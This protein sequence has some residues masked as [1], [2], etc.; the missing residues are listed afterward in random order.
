MLTAQSPSLADACPSFFLACSSTSSWQGALPGNEKKKL[1]VLAERFGI[2]FKGQAHRA[3]ADVGVM[4]ELLPYLMD[5]GLSDV[6]A[7]VGA[8]RGC[9]RRMGCKSK[10]QSIQTSPS[11]KAVFGSKVGLCHSNSKK[12][13]MQPHL[14]SPFTPIPPLLNPRPPSS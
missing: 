1:G 14:T 5:M 6:T 10:E 3:E 11:T 13:Q 7:Q 9:E 8:E 2:Q 12:K 4:L